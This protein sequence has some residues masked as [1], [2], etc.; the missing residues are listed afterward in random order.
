MKVKLIWL[1]KA[2]LAEEEPES[3]TAGSSKQ[4]ER[5]SFS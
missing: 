3:F 5:V 1:L 4:I 2:R